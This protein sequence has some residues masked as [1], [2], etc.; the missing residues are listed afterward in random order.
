[1]H[2]KQDWFFAKLCVPQLSHIQ[3]PMQCQC[4]ILPSRLSNLTWTLL[5]FATHMHSRQIQTSLPKHIRQQIMQ[6]R[7]WCISWSAWTPLPCLLKV[8]H[9]KVSYAVWLDCKSSYLGG[10]HIGYF[11][12]EGGSQIHAQQLAFASSLGWSDALQLCWLPAQLHH[13]IL[14]IQFDNLIQ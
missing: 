6:S 2:L 4:L 11:Q 14:H 9:R 10:K 12:C 3:S 1:M 13:S 7:I 5:T 8:A